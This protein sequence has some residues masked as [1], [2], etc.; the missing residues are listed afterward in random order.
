MIIKD[1]L[2]FKDF[3]I[4]DE[5]AIKQEPQYISLDIENAFEELRKHAKDALWMLKDD[6]PFYRG[7]PKLSITTGFA[8]VDPSATMRKSQNTYNYYTVILDNHP[9]YK[10]FPKR[11]RS[12]IGST[13]YETA[14]DYV[15]NDKTKTYVMIPYDGIKIGMINRKDIWDTY[16]TLFGVRRKIEYFNLKFSLADIDDSLNGL[17][18]FDRRLKNNDPEAIKK[19]NLNESDLEKY[20]NI[21]LEEIWRA[22]SPKETGF[23]VHTTKTLPRP[24]PK[25]S[26]VWVGGKVMLINY[27]TWYLY[28]DEKVIREFLKSC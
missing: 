7:D 26:E 8:T 5:A 17:K 6:T 20:K 27:K 24:L 1:H 3:L 28:T 19:F 4:L 25:D 10:D 13:N 21:F 12:F 23:T 16:I 14:N 9:D 18:D 15:F 22:Y 11:S 2:S